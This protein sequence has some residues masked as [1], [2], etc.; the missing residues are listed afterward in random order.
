MIIDLTNVIN[1]LHH[2]WSA[3]GILLLGAF[4]VF[5]PV[6]CVVASAIKIKESIKS[7]VDKQ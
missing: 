3:F 6:V 4:T 2:L 5:V 7:K 1:V